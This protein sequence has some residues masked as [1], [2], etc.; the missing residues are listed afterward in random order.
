MTYTPFIV[1]LK[2]KDS[3]MDDFVKNTTTSSVPTDDF[4]TATTTTGIAYTYGYR[5]QRSLFEERVEK[6][7]M[8]DKRTLAEMLALRDEELTTKYDYGI[9]L[10]NDTISVRNTG[11][12]NTSVTYDTP[13]TKKYRNY[14]F[15]RNKDC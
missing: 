3:I 14:T 1:I 11:E 4:V 12:G 5:T 6:Y 15:Q 8:C 7:M 10:C 2:I 13:E 9:S